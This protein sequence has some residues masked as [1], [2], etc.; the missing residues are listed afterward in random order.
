MLTGEDTVD[1]AGA[2][3]WSDNNVWNNDGDEAF[4][5]RP[6]GTVASSRRCVT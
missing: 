1:I 3:R 2:L 4:L 6:D 5:L